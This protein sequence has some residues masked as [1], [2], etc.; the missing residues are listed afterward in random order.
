MAGT[1][2]EENEVVVQE[3]RPKLAE[4]PK[5]AVLIHNDD[6][7]TMDFVVEVLVRFFQKTQ[8]EAV[9]ITLRVHHEG[10]GVA[11]IY[12]F[13]IAETKAAQVNEYA[14]SK[15]HPLKATAEPLS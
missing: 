12:G 2:D 4:P 1:P 14:R 11:G 6:Y 7:T 9:Q 3:G 15:G 10:K 5:Y 13:E 8:D